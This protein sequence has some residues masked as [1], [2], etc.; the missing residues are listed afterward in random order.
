MRPL[1]RE[2]KLGDI[3]WKSGKVVLSCGILEES[4]G[5]LIDEEDHKRVVFYIN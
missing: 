3:K 5:R 2:Q 4:K 1:I